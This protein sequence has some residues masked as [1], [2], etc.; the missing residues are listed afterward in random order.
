MFHLDGV[1]KNQTH[2][3]PRRYAPT[4]TLVR[5]PLAL[6]GSVFVCFRVVNPSGGM[7][8]TVNYLINLPLSERSYL[9]SI[10]LPIIYPAL[11]QCL[12]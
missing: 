9:L 11:H 2:R 5:F 6:F 8:E 7:K 4:S 10:L 1:Q 12:H 3:A